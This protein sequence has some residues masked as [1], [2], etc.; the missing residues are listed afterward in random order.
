[1]CTPPRSYAVAGYTEHMDDQGLVRSAPPLEK[2]CEEWAVI[3]QEAAQVRSLG[4]GLPDA[5][6]GA[7]LGKHG[8]DLPLPCSYTCL[9]W[10]VS[11]TS[12][13][14]GCRPA[15][16]P[17][18]PCHPQLLDEALKDGPPDELRGPFGG[19]GR[20]L[21][22]SREA[23]PGEMV[24]LGGGGSGGG[25]ASRA[26][27]PASAPAS[28]DGNSLATAAAAP[29]TAAEDPVAKLA[30]AASG[31]LSTH[32]HTASDAA[33]SSASSA[34]EAKDAG[35]GSEG[36]SIGIAHE[37]ED[38]NLRAALGRYLSHLRSGSDSGKGWRLFREGEGLHNEQHGRSIRLIPPLLCGAVP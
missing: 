25:A 24:E 17:G 20:Y 11:G 6:G 29:T 3:L 7:A 14:S 38:P 37:D 5:C 36:G 19:L 12:A 15:A 1:M 4:G 26:A 28:S 21:N 32:S 31:M 8:R 23:R 13:P 10:T 16:C 33:A 22:P 35:G 34:E 18:P 27:R 9:A 30:R 2:V